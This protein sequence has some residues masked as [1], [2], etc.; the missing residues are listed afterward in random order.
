MAETLKQEAK[1]IL[2][3]TLE[4]YVFWCHDGCVLHNLKE[5][6]DAMNTM[7]DEIYAFH[8]NAEKNDFTNWVRDIIKDK[9]LS[10]DLQKAPDRARAAKLVASRI[11]ILNERLA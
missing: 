10:R 4:G 1:R 7:T 8:A 5:L 6:G 2:S 11:T 3:D 9:R